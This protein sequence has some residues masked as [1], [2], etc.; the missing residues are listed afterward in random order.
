MKMIEN[1]LKNL[2]KNFEIVNNYPKIQEAFCQ[3]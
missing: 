2:I 3:T 1:L